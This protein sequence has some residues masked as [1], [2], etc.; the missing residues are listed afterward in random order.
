VDAAGWREM[1][2]FWDAEVEGLRSWEGLGVRF[3]EA[4]WIVSAI[5]RGRL[6]AMMVMVVVVGEWNWAGDEREVLTNEVHELCRAEL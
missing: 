3:R 5:S 4:V 2:C 6:D 1:G